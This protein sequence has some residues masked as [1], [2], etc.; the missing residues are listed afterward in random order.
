MNQKIIEELGLT[1][2]ESKIYMALLRLGSAHAGEITEKT[3]IHRRN[4]YDSIERLMRKGLVSH[5]VVDNKKLFNP[6]NPERFLEIIDEE[7]ENLEL[8]KS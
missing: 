3:G 2:N 4:V 8:K 5:V 7:K 1:K 6:A